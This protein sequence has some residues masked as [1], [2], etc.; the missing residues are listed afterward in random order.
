MSYELCKRITLN[1]KKN[2]IKVCIASNNLRPIEYHT[3]G[4]CEGESYK[5]YTFE[6][7]LI[8]LYEAMQTGC[9]QISTI[10]DNTENFEYA[11]CKVREYFRQNNINSYEDLYEK[12][13]EVSERKRFEFAGLEMSKI[14]DKWERASENGKKY[15]EWRKT[16]DK[17][18]VKEMEQ[19]FYL[20][21]IW[22]VYGKSFE[23]W[24]KALFE[25]IDG[26]FE[27]VAYGCYKITKLG[28]YDRGY[29]RFYYGGY[30]GLKMSYKKAYIFVNDMNSE[31]RKL[32]IVKAEEVA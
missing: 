6:D 9:I 12:R 28:K 15:D 2:E 1:K 3:C 19:K 13:G 7:K 24:K 14:E 25:N 31:S 18:L 8:C 22:E 32:E 17:E 20:E 29:S 26:E 16:Q 23:I 4:L 5:N 21:S 11:M 30:S 10:N 27:V